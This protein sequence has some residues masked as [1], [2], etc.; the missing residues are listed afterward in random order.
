MN[1]RFILY[2][3]KQ[4]NLRITK[5]SG[6]ITFTAIAAKIYNALLLN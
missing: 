1:N 3:P 2:F 5:N 4:S 6:V